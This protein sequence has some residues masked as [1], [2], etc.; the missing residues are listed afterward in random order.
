MIWIK[1]QA[2]RWILV[3]PL[4]MV[5]PLSGCSAFH[6][7][8]GGAPVEQ[9]SI[10]GA[11]DAAVSVNPYLLDRKPVSKR[12]RQQFDQALEAMRLKQWSRAES[13]LK[14]LNADFPE[15]SGPWLNLG[16]TYIALERPEQAE[17][18]LQRAITVNPNNLDAY[19]QLAAL[20]RQDG[21]F[22]SAEKL[23][24]QALEVWPDHAPSHLNLGILYDVY[25]GELLKADE[26]YRAYQALQPEPDKRVA[27]WLLDLQRQPVMMAR[28]G[29]GS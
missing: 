12:A 10:A 3:L 29:E 28:A 13:T 27:G 7:L 5:L 18:A 19:N 25:L 8:S 20:R 9:H 16:I 21:D 23:Y 17:A 2:R 15:L 11:T 1:D 4:S 14:L 24:Q 22:R 26:H 6:S